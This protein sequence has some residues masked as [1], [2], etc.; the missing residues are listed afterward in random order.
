MDNLSNSEGLANGQRILVTPPVVIPD[1]EDTSE[2]LSNV[3]VEGGSDGGGDRST[4]AAKP[5]LKKLHFANVPTSQGKNLG[6][7]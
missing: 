6:T 1:S 2:V 3:N 5:K 4:E 7:W